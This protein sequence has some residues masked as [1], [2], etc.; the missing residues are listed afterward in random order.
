LTGRHLEEEADVADTTTQATATDARTDGQGDGRAIE[1][2]NPAT[3]Q[4]IA[5]VP[6]ISTEQVGEL[7]GRARAA[8]PS[9]E[10]L[11]FEGRA[12]V[13][14]RAQKWIIDN[15]D[16]IARTIVSETG[17]T[18][19]DAQFAE[20]SYAAGA[21]GFWA[22][23]APEYLADEKVRSTSPFVLGRKL[24]VRYAP[25]GV[26]GVIGP[27]NYPLTN[28]FGDCIPALAAGNGV[29][30][31]P[32]SL[33]PLTSLL[34][35]EGLL[36]SGLPEDL[37]QVAVG[38]GDVGSELI[39]HVDYVMFTGS[40]EVGKKVME[41]AAKTLTPV[42]LELGGKDPMIVLADADL[43]RAANSAVYY[44]MQNGGQTCISVERV[45]VEDPVYDEFVA[46]VE[47]KMRRLRQGI[48]GDPG[49]V[50]IGAV[51]SPPQVELIDRHVKD[52]L[53]KGAR[54]VTG[55]RR[56]EGP[57]DFY[58]P[59]LLVDVDH[60]ME[61]MTEETFG[62]TL[63]V[64]KVPDVEEA[65]RLAN[66]SPYGLQ[67]SVWTHD[68]ARGERLAR[69]LEA[70][71]VTVNDAQVNYVAL[72]LPM[73]GWKASG[74]GSRHGAD[75]IRKYTKKQAILVTRLAPKRELHMFPYRAR[76]TKLVGWLLR[77]LYGRG[78]RD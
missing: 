78:R 60:S 33:T 74:L 73:G 12:R 61:C 1:V 45:Y 36:E 63:P 68:R 59:T 49:A 2:E 50:E 48:P 13:L 66:D 30:L 8:Q 17:K 22:K 67:A 11:G 52:A 28:S 46:K 69:Q 42:G 71:V 20:V 14:R 19:E 32:A 64:M 31:K 57:G 37:F 77:L 40:T 15:G 9:W 56:G 25:V 58:E 75:G 76:T 21:F 35:R 23:H 65:L 38:G 6:T 62:P 10:A 55:G 44:S 26:V 5:R 18:Y 51:T 27:W 16:Q 7:V 53:A 43:E 72:E 4:V 3:G 34:M 29:V 70:G 39:D 24:V 54:V 47:H 41:R